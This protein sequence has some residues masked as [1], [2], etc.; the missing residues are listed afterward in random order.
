MPERARLRRS[1]VRLR[2]RCLCRSLVRL[3][4]RSLRGRLI[5]THLRSLIGLRR[6]GLVRTSRRY[7]LLVGLLHACCLPLLRRVLMGLGGRPRKLL[8]CWRRIR[9]TDRTLVLLPSWCLILR[10]TVSLGT[11]RGLGPN[12]LRGNSIRLGGR[13]L[14]DARRN[15]RATLLSHPCLSGVSCTNLV[16]LALYLLVRCGLLRP[17][18]LCGNSLLPRIRACVHRILA[19]SNLTCRLRDGHHCTSRRHTSHKALQRSR[20]HLL[21]Q[22]LL[23]GTCDCGLQEHAAV[24]VLATM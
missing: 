12:L 13:L 1:L 24:H 2:S 6:R 4:G 23:L 15:R 8:R 21:F 9:L 11:V 3:R 16:G 22:S 20:S 10:R 5:R 18:S 7:L 17:L 19:T 14:H